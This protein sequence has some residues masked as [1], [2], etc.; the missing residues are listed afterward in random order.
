MSGATWVTGANGFIGRH[1]VA[2][3]AR[4]GEPVAGIG[5]G[6]WAEPAWRAAGLRAW[7]NADIDAASLTA[8]A[9]VAGP[10]RAVIHLAGGASV[11]ASLRAPHEDF[12]RTVATSLALLDW[13]RGFAA[14][15]PV[16]FASS[17]AVYGE[18]H[19]GRIAESAPVDPV[20]PYGAHKAMM[21]LASMAFARSY[22][23]R[24][25]V[26]RL[27]S[28]Y[29]PGL[30]KQ[31]LWDL[32]GKL[33]AGGQVQL[34]G[35]GREQRDWLHVAD[36]ARLLADAR[37][38]AA[39]ADGCP[40]ILNGG[41]GN[42]VEIREVAASL[43]KAWGREDRAQFSGVGRAGDPLSLV[44]DVQQLHARD[45]HPTV[46]LEDGLAAVAAW[47]RSRTAAR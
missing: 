17:A 32:C 47:Y 13:L 15:V 19:A 1:V 9:Q 18:G 28:V 43:A 25:A 22:G 21:E 42:G 24:V 27:F 36:A 31:L 37:A 3:L 14:G 33:A 38:W 20:S 34:S 26:I 29:G 41:T 11:A 10:P 4:R 44:A 35:S 46:G 8:L 2:E 5:H 7:L 6:G 30:E 23:L 45:F 16:V 39:S 12:H 40:L